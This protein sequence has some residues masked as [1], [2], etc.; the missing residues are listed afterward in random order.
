MLTHA[1]LFWER[2]V[3]RKYNSSFSP[4]DCVGTFPIYWSFHRSS[5]LLKTHELYCKRLE[6]K[7]SHA[8]QYS[9]T[10]SVCSWFPLPDAFPDI[11]VPWSVMFYVRW[12]FLSL[13]CSARSTSTSCWIWRKR[14]VLRNR[15][16]GCQKRSLG[17]N[18]RIARLPELS[19]NQGT[20]WPR[21]S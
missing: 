18:K 4:Q 20:G 15:E 10:C 21:V 19:L 5:F 11:T 2:P 16:M 3:L 9:L 14:R 12:P 17:Q 7:H 8:K 1:W 6:I 13:S